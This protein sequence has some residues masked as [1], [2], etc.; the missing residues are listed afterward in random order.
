[1]FVLYSGVKDSSCPSPLLIRKFLEGAK[2]ISHGPQEAASQ[3]ALRA[4][5]Q[6]CWCYWFSGTR[7]KLGCQAAAVVAGVEESAAVGIGLV[8]GG[9][10]SWKKRRK[11]KKQGGKEGSERSQVGQEDNKQRKRNQAPGG[12]SL[13]ISV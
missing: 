4:L 13:Y 3:I 12:Y 1:M 5:L 7:P 11:K 10:E 2:G 6:D 9:G 8:R